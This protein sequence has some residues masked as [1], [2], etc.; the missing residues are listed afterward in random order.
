MNDTLRA[1]LLTFLQAHRALTLAYQDAQGVAACALWYAVNEQ[2]TLY[3]MSALSTRHGTAL[4]QGGEVAFTVHK[5]EQPWQEIQ[6]VQGRGACTLVSPTAREAVWALYQQ[7]FPFVAQ[8]PPEIERAL[9]QAPL[10]Q[11]TPHWLRLIDN[12][13]GFGF[14]EE[15]APPAP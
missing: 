13:R 2:L 5:D 8:A 12:R 11:I 9:Q 10:W 7:R 14:K 4:A 15:W 1:R 6:G 3:F